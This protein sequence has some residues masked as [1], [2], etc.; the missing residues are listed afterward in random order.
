MPLPVRVA[1]IGRRA[2]SL[3]FSLFLLLPSLLPSF[4]LFSVCVTFSLLLY[5]L[6][7]A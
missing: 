5:W 7:H 3:V 2:R 1:I 4:R 6:A